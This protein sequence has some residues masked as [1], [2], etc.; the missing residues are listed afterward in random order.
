MNFKILSIGIATTCGTLAVGSTLSPAQAAWINV[1]GSANFA[2]A[3]Q[4]APSSDT[5]TFTSSTVESFKGSLFSALTVDSAVNVADVKLAATASPNNY[6]GTSTNP[7]I[8]FDKDS[9]LKFVIDNPFNVTR[10]R[11][12][13]DKF[14]STSALF[15]FTGAFYKNGKQLSEGILTANT[16]NKLP[17]S[18]S[19]TIKTVPEPLTILGSITALGMGAAL[20]KKQAQKQTKE[21]VTA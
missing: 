21:N 3:N 4:N 9:D 20:R 19:M 17:G 13:I 16:I 5:I 10:T 8:T 18:Y 1:V 6:T 12:T 14:T 7:F 2:N 15:N 11:T